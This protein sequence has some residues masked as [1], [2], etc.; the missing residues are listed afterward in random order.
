MTKTYIENKF[1]ILNIIF[2]AKYCKYRVSKILFK[3]DNPI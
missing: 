2:F 1:Y 3:Y